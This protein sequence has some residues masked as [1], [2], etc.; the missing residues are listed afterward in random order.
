MSKE[1]TIPHEKL[2][3]LIADDVQATR[4]STRL[5]LAEH[6]MV[7]V[8]AIAR[9]GEEAVKLARKHMPD[10]AIMDINMPKMDGLSA[11]QAMA[12]F[13]PSIANIIISSEKDEKTLRDAMTIGAREYLLKPFTIEEIIMAVNRVSKI[14]LE[15]RKRLASDDQA[16]KDREKY[17]K[18]LAHEYAKTRRV[19]NEALEVF[20]KLATNPKCELHWLMNLALIYLIRRK[21]GQLK[22]LAARLE[23]QTRNPISPNQKL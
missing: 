9:D 6:P 13:H 12:E 16:R 22:N 4:R 20:E 10:I 3:V 8:V 14:V 7:E 1:D 11:I 15:N 21:W 18:Q 2:R 23:K 5:M 19:D 17:L